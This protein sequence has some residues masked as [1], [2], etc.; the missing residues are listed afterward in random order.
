MILANFTVIYDAC[1]LYPAPL[2]DLMIRLALTGKFRAKWTAQIQ[3][4]WLDAVLR[5]R[6]D[7]D[8][9]RLERTIDRMNEAV[10]DCL[11]S[12]YESLIDDFELPDPDDRHVLAAAIRAGAQCIVT[13][14]LRDFPADTLKR[15]D[16]FARHPDA[17]VLDL[18]DLE[19]EVVLA[20]VKQQRAA[21]NNPPYTPEQLIDALRQ[22]GLTGVASLLT[23]WIEVI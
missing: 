14:N 16:I 5:D 20:A 18:V 7:L 22:V 21:L 1:L 9:R 8:R 13:T 12:D 23:D 3:Q 6:P 2:R 10:P 17:F 4:E 15:F 11:V 19:A